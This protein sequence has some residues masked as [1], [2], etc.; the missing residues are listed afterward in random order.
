L[1]YGF[2]RCLVCG[3]WMSKESELNL[4]WYD[5]KNNYLFQ[6]GMLEGLFCALAIRKEWWAENPHIDL[7]GIL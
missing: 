1:V 4:I 6:S 5:A 2:D 7:I 3:V